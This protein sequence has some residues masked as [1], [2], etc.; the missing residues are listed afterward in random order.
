MSLHLIPVKTGS[1]QFPVFYQNYLPSADNSLTYAT[2]VAHKTLYTASVLRASILTEQPILTEGSI[3]GTSGQDIVV[4]DDT[5]YRTDYIPLN[6]GSYRLSWIFRAGASGSSAWVFKYD[7]NHNFIERV[8][9]SG[10]T[11]TFTTSVNGYIRIVW[12]YNGSAFYSSDIHDI[13]LTNS[14][15]NGTSCYVY[16]LN[17]LTWNRRLMGIIPYTQIDSRSIGSILV[18]DNFV[19]LSSI[20]NAT[21]IYK[22]KLSD[23]SFVES[24]TYAAST[25]PNAYGK[26]QWVND[27]T[28]CMAYVNGFIFFD[29]STNQFTYA[30][31]GASYAIQDFAV[32]TNCIVGCRNSTGSNCIMIYDMTLQ[33]F[34]Y[35]SPTSTNQCV[36][37]YDSGKFYI[38]N[39]AYL[40]IMDESTELID[41]TLVMSWTRPRNICI[42]NQT[43]FVACTSSE[44]LFIYDIEHEV[45]SSTYLQW[46]VSDFASSYTDVPSSFNGWYFYQK[47]TLLMLHDPGY[48][49]YNFGPKMDS[50]GI[51]YNL[52]T[53]NHFTYDHSC[54]EFH[55]TYVTIHD[56]TITKSAAEYDSENHIKRIIM[57]KSEYNVMKKSKINYHQEEGD[58]NHE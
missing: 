40:Y 50:L 48:S 7:S 13:T 16:A 25:G 19:Y 15:T 32:G 14:A 26:M 4:T 38:A 23:L 17:L 29:T 12:Y 3:N 35:L 21:K 33:T 31:S 22:F 49:K 55:D 47:Q 30:D 42:T 2:T 51:M 43:V 52:S 44:R 20:S 54:I 9:N 10:S 46:T 53:A 1:E 45:H 8:G 24:Y 5:R 37:C 28:I 34:S 57:N 27:H 56:K 39:A 58:D 41:R 18:D 6:A 36:V 11:M